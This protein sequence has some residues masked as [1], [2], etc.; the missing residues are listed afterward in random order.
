MTTELSPADISACTGGNNNDGVFGGDGIVGLIALLIV[1]SMFGGFGFGGF[2]GN[3]GMLPWLMY[4]GGA[5]SPAFNGALTRG[6]LCQDM[7]FN[8]LDNGVRTLQESVSNLHQE[9]QTAICGVNYNTAQAV[10]SVNS[11]LSNEFRTTDNMIM[12]GGFDTQQ[13]I[14]GVSN[15]L[16]GAT[17]DIINSIQTNNVQ[18][19]MNTNAIQTQLEKC[20]CENR[21]IAMQ[22][23]FDMSNYNTA[24]LQAIDKL[25]DRIVDQINADRFAELQ[26][27]NEALRI[28]ANNATL[29][30]MI[31]P[32]PIPAF[33]SCNPWAANYGCGCN[34]GCGCG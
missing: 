14:N 4:N 17:R 5:N 13:A 8:T 31:K 30:N 12:Q 18:S 24:T 7:N 16:C 19:I 22:N 34:N 21:E 11:N 15:Q 33:Q 27:E 32:M 20:C 3:G 6:E 23:R 9:L 1:A 29:V 28:E 2:G 26:K 10:N 25:G